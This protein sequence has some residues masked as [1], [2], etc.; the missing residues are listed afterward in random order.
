MRNL[1]VSN[2][3]SISHCFFLRR[4]PAMDVYQK[5]NIWANTFVCVCCF[6]TACYCK[7]SCTNLSLHASLIYAQSLLRR[8]KLWFPGKLFFSTVTC[9]TSLSQLKVTMYKR[10]ISHP[11]AVFLLQNN[12]PIKTGV[13][14]VYAL[15][16][17]LDVQ[18]T[19]S[20]VFSTLIPA[21]HHRIQG[22]VVSRVVES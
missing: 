4:W 6:Y 3:S 21:C 2:T 1:S 5:E 11:N 19:R 10:V 8:P 16:A 12:K 18:I 22:E 15:S 14:P 13:K 7:R 9:C 20:C 17:P